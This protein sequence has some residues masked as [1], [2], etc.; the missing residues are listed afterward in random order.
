MGGY[1]EEAGKFA[2]WVRHSAG[3]PT[4]VWKRGGPD[5]SEIATPKRER[6]YRPK[7]SD[8]ICFLVNGG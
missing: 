8:T 6:T 5:T 7:H 4:F 1:G 3:Y 2:F